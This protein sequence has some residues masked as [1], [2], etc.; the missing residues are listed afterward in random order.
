MVTGIPDRPNVRPCSPAVEDETYF[1]LNDA[2][3]LA[4]VTSSRLKRWI[5]LGVATPTQRI[6]A[7]G[8]EVLTTGFSLADVGYLHLL[9]HLV[10]EGLDLDHAV[11]ILYHFMGRFGPPGPKWHDAIVGRGGPGRAGVVAYAPDE[12]L[13]TLAILG[14]EGAGQRYFNLL[15]SLL[16]AGVT[17]ESLLIPAEFLPYVEI[18]SM[19]EDGHPVVR[20]TRIRTD[21]IRAI[22]DRYGRRAVTEDYYPHIRCESIDP[23]V[24]FE[25]YLDNAA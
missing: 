16:P 10:N 24:E 19:K 25:L 6:V 23:S 9:R 14:P 21:A 18:N 12:W 5:R 8:Q 20:G 13:A 22:F 1:P 11:R 17:L 2:A 3:R 7:P 4:C 15:G